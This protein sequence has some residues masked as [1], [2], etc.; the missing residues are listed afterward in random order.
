MQGVNL[1]LNPGGDIPPLPKDVTSLSE[2]SLMELFV[3]LT[4]WSDYASTQ[5][6]FAQIDER[7]AQRNL[8]MA[9]ASATSTNWTGG[10][11]D[12]VAIA[13]AKVASDPGVVAA[14]EVLDA[15]HAYRK[16][17][18]VVASNLERDASVVSREI[19]RRTSG[20]SG[21]ARRASRWST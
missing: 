18:E 7:D 17:V 6:V 1:P 14:R 5:A 20:A 13:K 11:D 3:S 8:D 2:E 19:T 4:G 12:R 9:E 16:L 21:L 15:R 10:R